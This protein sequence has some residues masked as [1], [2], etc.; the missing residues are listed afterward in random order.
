MRTRL[1]V[2]GKLALLAIAIAAP[3]TS[4]FAQ[5][6]EPLRRPSSVPLELATALA[7]AG[8]FGSEPQILVGELPEWVIAR[9]YLPRESRVVGSAFIGTTVIGILSVPVSSDTLLKEFDRELRQ[10]GW[11]APPIIPSMGGV[12][13][14]APSSAI[15]GAPRRITLCGDR[16]ILNASILRQQAS[17]TTVIIRLSSSGS[18]GICNPPPY[19]PDRSRPNLPTLYDPENATAGRMGRE[20]VE[21]GYG[22]FG[23]GTRLKT[24]MSAGALLEHYGRQLQ[25][26]GW[27]PST[28]VPSISGHTW[29]RRDSTGLVQLS[30][31]V[32][33][34]GDD[35]SCREV[36]LSVRTSRVP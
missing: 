17:S 12:F 2:L 28:L 25:D 15:S 14:P 8:G 31:I 35:A 9:L 21:A 4:S 19:P 20:C 30:L 29:T 27:S 16:Q 26:S 22:S 5:E 36:E 32:K 7:S 24:T 23:S 10:R 6:R 13:R 3:A 18:P 34:M 33:P 1:R 11:K